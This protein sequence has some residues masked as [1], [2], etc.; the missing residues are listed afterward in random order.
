MTKNVFVYEG[1][2][3]LGVDNKKKNTGFKLFSTWEDLNSE[4]LFE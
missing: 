3:C 1:N 2:Q 4:V